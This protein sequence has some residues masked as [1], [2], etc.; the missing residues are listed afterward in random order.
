MPLVL[1]QEG[2]FLQL[3]SGEMDGKTGPIQTFTPI[4]SFFGTVK[5]GTRIQITAKEGYWTLLYL[6]KGNI[7]IDMESAEK[8]Q[9]LVFEKENEDIIICAEE[10]SILLFLSAEPIEEPIAAK[11][12]FVM[13]SMEEIEE[14]MADAAAGKFGR[15]T[16]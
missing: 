16:Y 2:V 1:E 8:Y 9:L 14:A 6:V 12:N 11:D 5:K 4:T 10:D 13:N 7:S 15:L 3:A